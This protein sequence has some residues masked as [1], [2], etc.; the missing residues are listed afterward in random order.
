MGAKCHMMD[1]GWKKYLPFVFTILLFAP[2][3]LAA[4]AHRDYWPYSWY[5]TFSEVKTLKQ[6]RIYRIKIETLDGQ[7]HWWECP[8]EKE[9]KFFSDNYNRAVRKSGNTDKH[10]RNAWRLITL[11]EDKTQIK[12][13]HIILRTVK[14]EGGDF[15]FQ[16][17]LFQ[18][19]DPAEL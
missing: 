1:T 19:V 4:A 7:Q 13:L 5:D 6:V 15:V 10:V 2:F 3:V 9:I 11:F 8:H 14:A 18:S 12:A 17:Q 16:D